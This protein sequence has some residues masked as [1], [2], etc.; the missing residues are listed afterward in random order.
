MPTVRSQLRSGSAHC[1]L[2]LE[3]G[4]RKDEGGRKEVSLIKS[5]DPHLEEAGK[6][7]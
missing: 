3:G 1:D 6:N 2:E 5:R 4:R 7:S